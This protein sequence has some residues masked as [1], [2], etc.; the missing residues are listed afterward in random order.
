VIPALLIN[1]KNSRH[2]VF[3]NSVEKVTREFPEL[4]KERKIFIKLLSFVNNLT[5]SL[6]MAIFKSFEKYLSVCR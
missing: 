6:R 1:E 4:L 3:V 2:D 5:G